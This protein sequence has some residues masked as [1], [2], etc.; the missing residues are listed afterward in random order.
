MCL[1]FLCQPGFYSCDKSLQYIDI[2]RGKYV[3]VAHLGRWSASPLLWASIRTSRW[4][5][6]A[7]IPFTSGPTERKKKGAG[8][9]SFQCP[10][11]VSNRT[12]P[13]PHLLKFRRLS[14]APSGQEGHLPHQASGGNSSSYSSSSILP[15]DTCGQPELG[16]VHNLL[17]SPSLLGVLKLESCNRKCEITWFGLSLCGSWLST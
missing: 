6:G 12:L 13:R 17:Q 9:T 16:S 4:K 11:R 5:G 1:T 8:P 10:Q 7:S 14:K 3:I 15:Y 2:Y